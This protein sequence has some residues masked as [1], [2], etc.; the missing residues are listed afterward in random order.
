MRAFLSVA[1]LQ[2]NG[3]MSA[4][5]KRRPQLVLNDAWFLVVA[6]QVDGVMSVLWRS[7]SLRCIVVVFAAA[8]YER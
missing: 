1:A 8:L 4:L 7:A 6:L 5:W 2:G 3:A